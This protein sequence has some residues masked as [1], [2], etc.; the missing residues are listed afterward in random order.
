MRLLLPVRLLDMPPAHAADPLPEL[1][2]GRLVLAQING[3]PVTLALSS[4]TVD[5]ILLNYPVVQRLRLF[6]D[7][8]INRIYADTSEVMRLLIGRE[9]FTPEYRS[10]HD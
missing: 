6:A 8:R 2:V 5:H 7:A 10:M 3:K 4:G 1:E 9:I